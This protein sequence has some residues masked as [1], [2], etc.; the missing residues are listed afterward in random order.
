MRLGIVALLLYLLLY[1]LLHEAASPE[2]HGFAALY[3]ISELLPRG[4][5][6]R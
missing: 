4:G 6:R 5:I 1:L 3:L 2:L